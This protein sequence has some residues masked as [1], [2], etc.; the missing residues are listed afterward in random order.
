[1]K[2]LL[3]ILLAGC[4]LAPLQAKAGDA[5]LPVQS[6]AFDGGNSGIYVRGDIG[7]SYLNSANTTTNWA[8]VGDAGIGYQ[9]DN[10]FRTDLTFN[11]T[12]NYAFA[13]SGNLYTNTILLNG[14]YDWKNQSAFTPYV[15]VGAG[16]GWQWANGAGA[17]N[18]QGLAVGLSAGVAYEM[19]H[20]LALDVGYRFHDILA[21][22]QSTPE[23]Q[24]AVGLRV[25]F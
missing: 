7:A 4:V 19:T 15:G 25:K 23:H 3:T 2:Y 14:Y 13:P 20:N 17:T 5:P 1:M 18:G 21:N 11:N 6:G 24:V 16:Y 12:G 9:F 22:N 8:Y 10:N